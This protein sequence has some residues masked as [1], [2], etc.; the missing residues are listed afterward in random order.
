[1]RIHP[2]GV[3]RRRFA[4][5][6]WR[7]IYYPQKISEAVRVKRNFDETDAIFYFFSFKKFYAQYLVRNIVPKHGFFECSGLK[8]SPI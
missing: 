5:T 2:G 8:I 6:S 4:D 3:L 7:N 1:M